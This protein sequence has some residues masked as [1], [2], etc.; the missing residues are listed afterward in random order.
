MS[1]PENIFFVD[2]NIWIYAFTDIKDEAKSDIARQIISNK[3]IALSIQ[4]INE[5]S[6]NLLKTGKFE[7]REIEE[8]IEAAYED[9]IIAEFSKDILVKASKLRFRYNFSFWDSMIVSSALYLNA[10]VLYSEDMQNNMLV[11]GN[12][13]I[14]NPFKIV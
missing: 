4:V 5:V 7:E 6:S 8:F 1:N 2:T 11:D 13:R 14:I 10:D 12:L 9:Y 3:R